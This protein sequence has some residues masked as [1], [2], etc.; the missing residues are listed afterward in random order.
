MSHMDKGLV[1]STDKGKICPE[2]GQPAGGCVCRIR[3]KTTVSKTDGVIRV[4]YETKGRK[5]KGVT[6]I[7]GLPLNHAGLEELARGLKQRFGAGGS[8]C[9]YSIEL[10]GDH[11]DQVEQE[12]HKSGY[13]VR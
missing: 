13:K 9:G 11:C 8:V 1:Y 12:L 4:R 7:S 3:G 2:C 6:V 5:G 10:Q